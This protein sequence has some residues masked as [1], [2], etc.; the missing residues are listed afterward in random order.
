MEI[1]H[2]KLDQV[3]RPQPYM[4]PHIISTFM[5]WQQPKFTKLKYFVTLTCSDGGVKVKMMY[6][7]Q[8]YIV[9]SIDWYHHSR[10]G[11]SSFGGEIKIFC[12]LEQSRSK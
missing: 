11:S 2:L 10:N 12:D 9:H 6:M 5:P 7:M 3:G 4:A 1:L 8:I